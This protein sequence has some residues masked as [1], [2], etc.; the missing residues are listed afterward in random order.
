MDSK[1][2]AIKFAEWLGDK[3][4]QRIE[5]YQKYE[6]DD[7]GLVVFYETHFGTFWS[8]YSYE[9]IGNIMADNNNEEFEWVKENIKT[10]EQLY[11]EFGCDDGTK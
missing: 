8:T 5:I 1:I 2:N 6:K 4:Y 3:G 9:D 7:D 11:E 10:T